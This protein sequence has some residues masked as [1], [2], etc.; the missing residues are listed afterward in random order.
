M[1]IDEKVETYFNGRVK[2]VFVYITSRCQLHC[3][4]CLYK[5]LLCPNSNDIDY[6]IL[7][8]LLE[9]FHKWGAYKLSFLGGEPTLY[10]D[11][12]NGKNLSDVTNISHK[13]GYKYIRI[14]TNG[15]FNPSFLLDNGIR[16]LDEITF[17]LDG[18]NQL[19]NDIV[20]GE[21]TY[22]KCVANI[23]NAIEL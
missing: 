12:I 18:H 13:I 21:G 14:D 2:Q 23:K 3:K 22:Q 9:T 20:R 4:Q 6:N 8:E 16:Q 17:S 5:P 19:T 1:K 7:I 11:K 10:N 15:Q